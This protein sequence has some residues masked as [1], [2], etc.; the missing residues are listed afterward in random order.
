MLVILVLLLV[1]I[2]IAHRL[3]AF[4]TQKDAEKLLK[5]SLITFDDVRFFDCTVNKEVPDAIIKFH[6]S[7]IPTARFLDLTYFRDINCHHKEDRC[8]DDDHY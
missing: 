6:R 1:Q 4:I 8:G 7:H 2:A 3:P 5:A